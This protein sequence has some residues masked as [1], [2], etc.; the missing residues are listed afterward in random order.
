MK[1]KFT[2][3]ATG[4]GS[5]PFH[6]TAAA[7]SAVFDNLKTIPFWPQLPRRSFKESMYVQYSE[8]LPGL[9]VNDS[10]KTIHIDTARAAAELEGAYTRYLENDIEYFKISRSHAEGLYAFM[11]R[12]NGSAGNIKCVKGHTT[13]P[14]SFALTVTNENKRSIMY[15][16]DTFEVLTKVLCMKVRWQARELKKL[17]PSV[18][19]F[20]DEPYLVS[21]GS[22]YVNIDIDDAFAKLDE[23]IAAIKEEGAIAG[24]HCCGNTDW[25]LLLKRDLDILNFDSYAFTKEFLLYGPDIKK[26]LE[27]GSTIAWGIVPTASDAI[28][29]ES[30]ASLVRK[31]SEGMKMLSEKG[32]PADR[33][34]SIVTPSC[35]VGSLDEPVARRVFEVLREL[36]ES[37]Q[38]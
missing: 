15:D 23:V 21:I 18:I 1:M 29:K 27:R 10:K 19:I 30:A 11:E 16:K 28:A 31:F 37:L 3:D 14:I 12:F 6:D 34:S 33:V 8:G 7:L 24:L 5:L 32:I 17:F 36:S 25:P 22:S 4:I 35:G 2:Y 26:F 38:K 13:G 20:I 9:V